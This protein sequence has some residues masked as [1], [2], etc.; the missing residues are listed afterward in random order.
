[1]ETALPLQGLH[2]PYSSRRNPT[3]YAFGNRR[4]SATQTLP[5][6]V[7]DECKGDNSDCQAEG[8]PVDLLF[9]EEVGEA[10][11]HRLTRD[12]RARE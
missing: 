6:K 10:G 1:M 8:E 3:C 9:G 2:F 5:V 12:S 4:E 11:S 7:H